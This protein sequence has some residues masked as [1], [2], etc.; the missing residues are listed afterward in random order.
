MRFESNTILKY[1]RLQ[2]VLAIKH[3]NTKFLDHKAR[4]EAQIKIKIALL[5]DKGELTRC[6]LMAEYVG[7]NLLDTACSK[8]I[9][10]L[11]WME[12]FMAVLT[13]EEWTDLT[14]GAKY[15]IQI[16]LETK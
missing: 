13:E 8:I 16:D 5:C 9:A 3:L 14:I 12:E 7:Y 15:Y 1:V 4:K 11:K 2:Y 6:G 10:G